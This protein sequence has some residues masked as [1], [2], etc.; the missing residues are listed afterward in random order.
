MFIF[1]FLQAASIETAGPKWFQMQTPIL[2]PQIKAD[3]KMVSMRGVLDAKRHYKRDRSLAEVP[4]HFQVS[5][6]IIPQCLERCKFSLICFLFVY[7]PLS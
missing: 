4:K 7:R 6:I 3:L 5:Y 2:T 1:M